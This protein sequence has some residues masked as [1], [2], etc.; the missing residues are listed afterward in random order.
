MRSPSRAVRIGVCFWLVCASLG[1]TA[2]VFAQP[3]VGAEQRTIVNLHGDLYEARFD[4]LATLFLVTTDGI[5]MTDPLG[6][7]AAKW[8]GGE[9]AQRFPGVPV[10]YVLLSHH[11]FDRTEGAIAFNGAETIAHRLFNEELG[12]RRSSGLYI[13]VKAAKRTFD[14]RQRITIG[15]RTV[16]MVYA[17]PVHARDMAVVYFPDER[18]VFAVDTLNV[19]RTPYSFGRYSPFDVA[20]WLDTMVGLDADLIVDGEGKTIGMGNLRV[21]QP[22]VHDLVE[23]VAAGVGSGRTLRQLRSEV[24]LPAHRANPNYAGRA[25]QIASVYRS[26]SVNSL[27]VTLAGSESLLSTQTSYCAGF[28][29]CNPF[30]GLLA[31]GTLGLE[32]WRGRV[33]VGGEFG[34]GQQLVVSRSSTLYDDAVA[35]RRSTASIFLRYQLSQ[36]RI[37]AN[38][39]FGLTAAASDTQGLD[40]VREALA[41]LGGR[42][43]IDSS[44]W[45]PGIIG[46]VDVVMSAGSRWSVRLPVRVSTVATGGDAFHPGPLG[47][48][49]GAGLSYRLTRR[50]VRG[51][52]PDSPIAVPGRPSAPVK[53]P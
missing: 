28:S 21:L 22:Y 15:G 45:F 20:A 23:A 6:R 37:G 47:V 35:N 18:V 42:H 7:E 4:G 38:V 41:P 46:G 32:Y 26:L 50:V 52:G 39:L 9:F 27:D 11:H 1:V 51:H 8:L 16:E 2:P 44:R 19:D 30:G 29:I 36:A 48:Q 3:S 10:R 13:D 14:I 12:A 31:G 43:P 17:G 5:L 53:Q 25:S 49:V 34:T 40:V 24:L 33:G